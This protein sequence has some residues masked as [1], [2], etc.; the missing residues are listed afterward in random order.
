[1][2]RA[3]YL[4]WLIFTTC[5]VKG[6]SLPCRASNSRYN[7]GTFS[8]VDPSA[9]F[10]T[11]W[12]SDSDAEKTRSLTSN[13]SLNLQVSSQSSYAPSQSQQSRGWRSKLTMSRHR[14]VPVLLTVL[15]TLIPLFRRAICKSIVAATSSLRFN[16]LIL[17]HM[18]TGGALA[19]VGDIIAQS[20]LSEDEER[21]IPPKD[22][23][24]IRTNA[25]VIFGAL[26]TGGAQHFI[27]N[28]L[29]SAF[30]QPLA[31]LA[32]AQFFFIPFCYY[33]TF[34]FMNPALRAGWEHGFGSEDAK[35]RQVELFSDIAS[36]IP[37]TLLRNWCFWL[38]VQF[39]QFNFIPAELN[40][41]FAAAF[42]VIWNAILS[43]STAAQAVTAKEA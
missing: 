18:A 21:S 4:H 2:S 12:Q 39:V 28:F 20:L 30:D 24:F 37:T 42:G 40:V 25:F 10:T 27:F 41:T 8:R 29:H 32:M 14:T 19:F 9:P 33:P 5:V 11:T 6:L 43:M 31:R 16:P 3:S 15:I 13:T 7:D 38:P 22:W 23:D 26:Y 17:Q 35:V 1:M 34:L 36:K